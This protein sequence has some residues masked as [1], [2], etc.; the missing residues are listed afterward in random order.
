MYQLTANVAGQSDSAVAKRVVEAG[1]TGT[2]GPTIA[3][4]FTDSSKPNSFSVTVNVHT[5][6]LQA[7]A[8]Q[9]LRL[10][11]VSVGARPI[12]LLFRHEASRYDK[13]LAEL[14]VKASS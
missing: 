8:D 2:L 14:G 11:A 12:T 4:V 3:P 13:L 9:L 5:R 7:T 1:V 10:G 6:D